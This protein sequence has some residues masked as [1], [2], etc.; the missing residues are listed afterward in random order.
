VG[1]EGAA[2]VRMGG[3]L[4]FVA[5][6]L[7]V[8]YSVLF[9]LL[10]RGADALAPWV[11]IALAAGGLL[12]VA[13]L[14]ALFEA[15][16]EFEPSLARLALVFGIL[17]AAGAALHGAYDLANA[18]HPDAATGARATIASLPSMVDPRGFATFG[19][20]GLALLVFCRVLYLSPTRLR[21]L[22]WLA[23]LSGALL[24]VIY[25]GRLVIVT[26]TNPVVIGPAAIEGLVVNPLFYVLLG[27]EF[28]KGIAGAR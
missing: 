5:A 1:A 24:V 26:P 20:A 16:R 11:A 25:V 3:L 7:G 13:V 23:G 12:T 8:L 9:V 22:W 2:F 14:L 17:S 18:L 28:R 19:L 21:R 4:A 27:L 6:A 10:L 15:V